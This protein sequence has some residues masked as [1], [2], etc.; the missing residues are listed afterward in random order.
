MFL[1]MI[2]TTVISTIYQRSAHPF[3][4]RTLLILTTSVPFTHEVTE[5]NLRQ[6][7]LEEGENVRHR[8]LAAGSQ[9]P[10]WQSGE[11]CHSHL[12]LTSRSTGLASLS[13]PGRTP[14]TA[15]P[16]TLSGASSSQNAAEPP[17][18]R[19]RLARGGQGHRFG[20][21]E[22]GTVQEDWRKEAGL[23]LNGKQYIAPRCKS[24]SRC[25]NAYANP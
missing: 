6:T 20:K 23:K 4:P 10:T 24:G 2:M 12:R 1:G 17:C 9:S 11:L 19:V 3:T 8:L 7:H 14:P 18:S 22:G 13:P 5:T 16:P 15:R 25:T 21:K